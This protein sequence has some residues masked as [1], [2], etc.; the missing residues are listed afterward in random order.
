MQRIARYAAVLSLAVWIGGLTFYALVVVPIGAET[1]GSTQQGFITQQVT[2]WLNRIGLVVLIILL[3]SLQT[4]WMRA[5]WGTL[6]LTLAALFLL[7]SQLDAL[8]ISS[9]ESDHATF[10]NWH[11]AYLL[12][13]ALQ[14]LAGL[15]HLWGLVQ[16]PS[17]T[18]PA[19]LKL[20]ERGS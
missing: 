3:P 15:G 20:P 7:H 9:Q 18:L 10:Y 11:R 6:A 17:A 5:T 13:T 14:W 4:G 8:L 16:S 2:I 12:V 1:I 19:T